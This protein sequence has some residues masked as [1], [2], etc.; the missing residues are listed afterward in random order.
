MA[1]NTKIKK[2][3]NKDFAK[4]RSPK[5]LIFAPN[6][7]I[8]PSSK[9][10]ADILRKQNRK[11]VTLPSRN[12][13]KFKMIHILSEK[14]LEAIDYYFRKTSEAYDDWDWNG[15]DVT[16]WLNNRVIERYNYECLIEIINNFKS[17]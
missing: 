17:L 13:S 4:V 6:F 10:L 3:A 8:A 12:A 7:A 16:L 9:Q 11:I 1:S 2:S 15:E 14:Q 5:P